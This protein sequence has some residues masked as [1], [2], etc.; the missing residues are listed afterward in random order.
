MATTARRATPYLD[1]LYFAEGPRYHDG[2][3]WYS[4][5][6]DAA[7][8]SAT[9]DGQRRGGHLPTRPSGLGWLPDGRL[10][11]VSMLDRTLRRRE[12]D[13]TLVVHGELRPWATFHA[14]D[15][16][17]SADGR[18]Y[19]GNFGFDLDALATGRPG[20]RR[21]PRRRSSGWIP[22]ARRT[23]RPPT[24]PSP[25]ARCSRPTARTLVVAESMAGRLQRVRGR[26]RRHPDRPSGVGEPPRRRT[27]RH[28]PGRRG[29]YLGGQRPGPGVPTGG[30]GRGG[31]DRVSTEDHCFACMLGGSDGRTLYLCTA[32]SSVG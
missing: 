15:M 7:V 6:Y 29:L 2:R 13:G 21:R 26:G 4:D 8:F 9:D 20:P 16:V 1:G 5:F 30:R 18:A 17:V 23:R 10:L 11:V 3:L 32:P 12:P 24:W 28:L 25:T 31:V 19:V 27:R 22:T 14:N